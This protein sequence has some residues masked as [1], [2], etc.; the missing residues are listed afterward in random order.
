MGTASSTPDV[1]WAPGM[2]R[3]E[4]GA[5]SAPSNKGSAISGSEEVLTVSGKT[6][7]EE[8]WTLMATGDPAFWLTE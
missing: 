2:E 5:S 1:R 4:G 8:D 7:T 3:E 6:G